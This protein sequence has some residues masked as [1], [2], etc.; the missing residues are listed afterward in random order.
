MT[1]FYGVR[2]DA[3]SLRTLDRALALGVQFWDT[4]DMYGPHTNEVL[5][6]KALKGRR[7][8]V[9]VA[10]KFGIVRDPQNPQNPQNPM[11][12]SI[13][14]KPDYVQSACEASLERL[15]TD[16]IDL[17]YQHRVDPD[18]A[19]EE[20]VGAM[21]EL[22]RQGKVRYLG[23]SEV[24]GETLRKA[25]RVHPISAV[26]SEFSLWSREAQDDILP[27]C[28]ELGVGFVAYSPLG[29]GFLTGD[30]QKFEDFSPQDY[31][32]LSPRFQG[33]NFKKNLDLVA[34]IQKMAAERKMA[35]AQ[36]ALAWV[37]NQGEDV[38]AIPGTKRRKFLEQNVQALDIRLSD[39]ELAA[40]ANAL[41]Q[42]AGARYP[43]SIMHQV[44]R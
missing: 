10:T 35:P 28:R 12:R 25:H 5:L 4:A 34:V 9:V 37:V 44:N 6:G 2:D 27:V 26:Q 42:V 20:T 17:Y 14:G 16:Y 8:N 1:D 13:C 30:I 15:Q 18:T 39:S 11:K 43:E 41:P 32:R 19:I 33:D 3:E 36:L 7:E 24:S 38:V 21:A 23:L 22:V 29:R 31:R 40:I